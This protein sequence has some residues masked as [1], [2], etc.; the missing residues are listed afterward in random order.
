MQRCCDG[1]SH[2]IAWKFAKTESKEVLMKTLNA[3]GWE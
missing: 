3:I 2:V 1:M